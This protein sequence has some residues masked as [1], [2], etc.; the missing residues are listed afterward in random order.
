MVGFR[1]GSL[2]SP[3]STGYEADKGMDTGD[4][5]QGEEGPR[6][7]PGVLGDRVETEFSRDGADKRPGRS[8]GSGKRGA[9]K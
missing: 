5:R 2:G 6:V 1:K 7:G 4:A 9:N 8:G 3:F